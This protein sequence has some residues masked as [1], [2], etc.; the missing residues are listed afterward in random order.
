MQA[1]VLVEISGKCQVVSSL[2]M[3]TVTNK[4]Y[5]KIS[6]LLHLQRRGPT[7]GSALGLKS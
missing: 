5:C 1:L 3:Y 6:V 7:D 2:T 4:N